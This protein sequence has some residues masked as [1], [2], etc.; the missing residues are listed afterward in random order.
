[1]YPNYK[2]LFQVL[3]QA[4]FL[5]YRPFCRFCSPCDV[6]SSEPNQ[7]KPDRHIF[8]PIQLYSKSGAKFNDFDR[9]LVGKKRWWGGL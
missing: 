5:F 9:G 8:Q 4:V 2:G 6:H 3:G 1:M 7:P